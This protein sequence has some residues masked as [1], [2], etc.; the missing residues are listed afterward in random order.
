MGTVRFNLFLFSFVCWH[1]PQ[2]Q[3]PPLPIPASPHITPRPTAT[4][5]PAV[6]RSSPSPAIAPTSPVQVAV[7]AH[8]RLFH[9]Q[10]SLTSIP[11]VPPPLDTAPTMKIDEVQSTKKAQRIAVHSHIKGLGLNDD[12]SVSGA[13]GPKTSPLPLCIPEHSPR[14]RMRL[15]PIQT[16]AANHH[17][18]HPVFDPPTRPTNRTSVL[19]CEG[20]RPGRWTCRPGPGPRGRQPQPPDHP[21]CQDCA[22]ILH[23]PLAPRPSPL[24]PNPL[25][26]GG[27]GR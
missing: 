24:P 18:R 9:P 20:H 23:R 15:T 12:G 6:R 16:L 21:V 10:R 13:T 8:P 26:A 1:N 3:L 7:S 11:P 5:A 4:W 17:P 2:V 14:D 27:T 22:T 25:E 19:C